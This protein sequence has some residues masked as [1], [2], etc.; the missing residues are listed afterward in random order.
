MNN[1]V[2]NLQTKES[3]TYDLVYNKHLDPKTLATISSADNKGYTSHD[4]KGKGN[5]TAREAS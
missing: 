2:N 3:L 5:D 4:V 1:I